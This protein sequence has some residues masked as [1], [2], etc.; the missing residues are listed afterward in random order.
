MAMEPESRRKREGKGRSE[1]YES[2]RPKIEADSGTA[3]S[4]D[5]T[6]LAIHELGKEFDTQYEGIYSK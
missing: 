4:D 5:E 3:L 2:K 1:E 6:S